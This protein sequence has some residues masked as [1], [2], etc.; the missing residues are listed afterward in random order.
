VNRLKQ[1][2]RVATRQEQLVVNYLAWITLAVTLI[3]L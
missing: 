1:L 3:W 2:Q